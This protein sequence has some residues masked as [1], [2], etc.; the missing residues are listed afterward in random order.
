MLFATVVA[1]IYIP[2]HEVSIFSTS[3]PK[4]S[5][6]CLFDGSPSNQYEVTSPW[7]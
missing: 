6:S 1:S 3:V 2:T 5:I 7:T 4:L